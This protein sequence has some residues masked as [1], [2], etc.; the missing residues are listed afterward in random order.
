MSCK[1]CEDIP[2]GSVVE[3]YVRVSNANV[4]IAGCEE[5]LSELI[6]IY[7][8]GLHSDASPAQ[9]DKSSEGEQ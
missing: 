5:H 1:L 9:S 8:L 6:R 7:K 4:L 3:T 2:E